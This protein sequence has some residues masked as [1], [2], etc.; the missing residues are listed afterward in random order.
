MS[1]KEKTVLSI[2]SLMEHALELRDYTVPDP[3]WGAGCLLFTLSSLLRE[4][5]KANI[6][7]MGFHAGPDIC[8][9]VSDDHDPNQFDLILANPP[10]AYE[11]GIGRLES[12]M[13]IRAM[14]TLADNGRASVI[15][16]YGFL[17]RQ[18]D[19]LIRERLYKN[20][21]ILSMVLLPLGLFKARV[22]TCILTFKKSDPVNQ[23]IEIND[24]RNCRDINLYH[25]HFSRLFHHPDAVS[26]HLS[27]E[28]ITEPDYFFAPEKYGLSSNKDHTHDQESGYEQLSLFPDKDLENSIIASDLFRQMFLDKGFPSIRGEELFKLRSGTKIVSSDHGGPY[29]VIGANGSYSS[30]DQCNV[31]GPIPTIIINRVGEHCGQAS[32][33]DKPG[34]I[35]GNAIYISLYYKETDLQYLCYLLNFMNLNQYKTGSG[36]PYI[37]QRDIYEKGYLFPPLDLQKEFSNKIRNLISL[38]TGGAY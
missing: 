9:S 35:T 8:C 5:Q 37:T 1:E 33:L 28:Q 15:M 30:T 31:H 38:N 7:M 32:I 18:T 16:P 6:K 12:K 11:G 14:D 19:H 21:E 23:Y 26:V 25:G 36:K 20:F 2:I 13:L 4:E 29:P 22:N 3:A 34:F 17:S 27:R 24:F 10:F